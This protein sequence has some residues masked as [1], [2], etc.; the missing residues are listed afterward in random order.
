VADKGVAL[1]AVDSIFANLA[2][3]RAGK[4][5]D[6]EAGADVDL[7]EARVVA[8]KEIQLLAGGAAT[9]TDAVL[10]AGKEIDIEAFTVDDSGAI[11]RA[12]R[13]SITENGP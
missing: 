6:I 5:I 8:G 13:V 12:R 7:T 2:V 11:I 3:I 4:E 10:R 9:L 1:N